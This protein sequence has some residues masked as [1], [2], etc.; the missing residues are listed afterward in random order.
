[1]AYNDCVGLDY[2]RA[3]EQNTFITAKTIRPF[4]HGDMGGTDLSDAKL[5]EK[6]NIWGIGAIMVR[7]IDKDRDPKDGGFH[8]G[9]NE[10]L[11][12]NDNPYHLGG[13]SV[14]NG[15]NALRDL[16]EACTR[17]RPGRATKSTTDQRNNPRAHQ[18]WR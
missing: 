10:D 13:L 15:S 5:G 1:M 14:Y 7:L 12:L 11:E 4:L 2:W 17:F 18:K 3:P 6:G 9:M 8:D 16:V